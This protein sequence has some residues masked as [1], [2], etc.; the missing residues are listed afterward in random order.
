MDLGSEPLQIGVIL[1]AYMGPRPPKIPYFGV[2]LG[3]FWVDLG[4]NRGQFALGYGAIPDLD[5]QIGLSDRGSQGYP[6]KYPLN[7]PIL[8]VFWG[9]NRGPKWGT[10]YLTRNIAPYE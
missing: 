10:G 9:Q 7:D 6:L 1:G 8:G 3:S 2:I 4:S 5:P